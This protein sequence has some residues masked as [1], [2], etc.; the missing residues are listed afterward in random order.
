MT[1]YVKQTSDQR[2]ITKE[3][4]KKIEIIQGF[5]PVEVEK[6]VNAFCANNDISVEDIKFRTEVDPSGG[7]FYIF[8]VIYEVKE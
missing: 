3:M 2:W 8:V 5:D 4:T 6:K 7:L 1:L